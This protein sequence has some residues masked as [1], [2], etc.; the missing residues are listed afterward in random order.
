MKALDEN[1]SFD[2]EDFLKKHPTTTTEDSS[3]EIAAI[4]PISLINN[5]KAPGTQIDVSILIPSA[6][7]NMLQSLS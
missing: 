2:I 6:I 1:I 4:D 7:L 3:K 5:S